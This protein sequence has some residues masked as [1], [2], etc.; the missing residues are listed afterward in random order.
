MTKEIEHK[1]QKKENRI[2]SNKNNSFNATQKTRKKTKQPTSMNLKFEM[3]I[4]I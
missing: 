1:T 4:V 2:E 3:Y